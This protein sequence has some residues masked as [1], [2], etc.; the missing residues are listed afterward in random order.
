MRKAAAPAPRKPTHQAPTHSGLSVV[1]SVLW[2]EMLGVGVVLT[3]PRAHTP[4]TL[5][6]AGQQEAEAKG[7][8]LMPPPTPGLDQQWTRAAGKM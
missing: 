1:S 6:S 2:Q 7:S 5:L 3:A 4:G 8:A